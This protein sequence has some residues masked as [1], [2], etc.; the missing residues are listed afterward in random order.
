MARKNYTDEFRRRAVD[1]YEST[2]GATLKAIAVD[3]GIWGSGERFEVHESRRTDGSYQYEFAWL[4]GPADGTYGF[5]IGGGAL[6]LE[7]LERETRGFVSSF[8]E[9]EGIGP[10]DFPSFVRARRSTRGKVENDVGDGQNPCRALIPESSL[11]THRLRN[12]S[13]TTACRAMV[14]IRVEHQRK[15]APRPEGDARSTPHRAATSG[16]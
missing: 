7:E 14:R 13:R 4:N 12:A 8:F 6:G 5:A 3:L 10:S 2:P 11:S 9:P 16:D 1:L 15:T